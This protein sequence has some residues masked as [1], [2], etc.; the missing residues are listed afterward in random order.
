[1]DVATESLDSEAARLPPRTKALYALGDH[2]VNL[3]LSSLSFFYAFF[4]AEIAGIRPALAGLIPLIGRIV[5]AVSDPAMGRISDL[6]SWRWGRRRPYFL[7]G[8][9][10]FGVCYAA[11]WWNVSAEAQSTRFAYYAAAYILYSLSTTVISVP[12]LALLPELTASY[13]ERTS[14]NTYRA[15]A[16]IL[17]ALL[18]ATAM[19]PLAEAFGGRADGFA[20]AGIVFGIWM[21]L[22][23]F[24]VYRATWE[25]PDFQRPART[26]FLAGLKLILQHRT[27]MRLIGLYLLGRIAIDLATAM[28]MFY[29][30]YWLGRPDDFGITMGLFLVAVVVALPVWL[31]I[32]EHTDKRTIF[33]FGAAWWVGAQIFL[34]LATPD[35]PRIA[36]FVGAVIAGVGYAVADVMPWSMLGDV[37]DEDELSTG[38]R[39]EGIYAGFFTFLRKLGGATGVAVALFVLDLS[40][41][42]KG[43]E[44]SELT[45]WMIRILTAGVPGVFVLLA[46]WVAI[47]YPL[48]RVRHAE[49]LEELRRRRRSVT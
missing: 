37:V 27:Y 23:W 42:Q 13:Q 15:S 43:A 2:T 19:R 45:L 28:F 40:G 25:R 49:I 8:M 20:A 48:G 6:T 9:L 3:S 35:W 11:L 4:L 32:S 30:T 21:I 14:L 36:I 33:I 41:Y 31:R 12:Y 34:I 18:A 39:R 24:V 10:P 38:E 26:P 7:I 29:F 22:P 46:G 16:A 47:R 44:Q 17:G 1:M 5:D